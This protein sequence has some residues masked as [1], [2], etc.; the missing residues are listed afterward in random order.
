MQA[1]F[2]SHLPC[3]ALMRKPFISTSPTKHETLRHSTASKNLLFH[4][5]FGIGT[6]S[7]CRYNNLYCKFGNQ[8]SRWHQPLTTAAVTRRNCNDS[9][10]KKLYL[11]RFSWWLCSCRCL[12]TYKSINICAR[13]TTIWLFFSQCIF[14]Q[15]GRYFWLSNGS[16]LEQ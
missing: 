14:K 13:R 3:I 5:S 6:S 11:H 10:G 1:F 15:H 8:R 9:S 7:Q 16:R 12:D 2:P 4:V